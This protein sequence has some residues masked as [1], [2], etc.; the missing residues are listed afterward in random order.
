MILPSGNNF[1]GFTA[2]GRVFRT[3][4]R[5]PPCGAARGNENRRRSPM[6]KLLRLLATAALALAWAVGTANVSAS[7]GDEAASPGERLVV[8]EW[9][10]FTVLQDENGKPI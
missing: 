6:T 3:L 10:T 5:R 7:P 4:L 2:V 8:H 9:G 1:R